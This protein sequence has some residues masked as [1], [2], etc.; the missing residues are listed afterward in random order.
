MIEST[1]KICLE[2][3]LMV[4]FAVEIEILIFE[5]ILLPQI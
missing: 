3:D 4:Y 1:A 2:S 5:D